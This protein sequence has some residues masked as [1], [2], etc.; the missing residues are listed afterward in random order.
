[1]AFPH[2]LETAKPNGL[3]MLFFHGTMVGSRKKAAFFFGNQRFGTRSFQ[4]IL[5]RRRYL[6]AMAER[7]AR[8]KRKREEALKA[9]RL[10]F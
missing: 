5:L 10:F 6:Q 3:E 9:Q 8:E 7:Q 1:M 4:A 2:F